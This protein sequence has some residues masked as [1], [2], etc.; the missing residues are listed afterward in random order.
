MSGEAGREEPL[1]AAM[2]PTINNVYPWGRSFDEYRRMFR[3]TDDDLRR[4]ILGSA[5]GP[6]SFNAVMNRRGGRVVSCDPLYRHDASEIRRR[7]DAVYPEMVEAR[8]RDRDRFVWN[9]IRSP[10]M[11]GRLRRAAMDEFLADYEAG[12]RSGGT[13][14]GRCRTCRS[15]TARSTCALF[16]LPVPVFR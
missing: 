4:R 3:L 11:L 7:I 12:R 13:W 8:T 16:A 1:S 14:P 9:V 10:D 2:E 15:A 5:D 6:A